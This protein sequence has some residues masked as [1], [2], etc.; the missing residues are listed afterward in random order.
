MGLNLFEKIILN[1]SDRDSIAVNDIVEVEIDG[2][3]IHDFFA[4]FCIRKFHEMGFDAVAKP[5]RVVFVYD[6]LVPASFVGD[7]DHHRAAETFVATYGITRIHRN[8]GVCHQLMHEQGYV[9]PGE[10]VVGTDSHTTT[11]GAIGAIATGIGYTEMA[12]VLGTGKLWLKVAP[13]IGIELTGMLP[14]GVFAKDVILRILGDIGSGG[15]NYR[16]LEFSGPVIDTMSIDSRLTLSNMAVE[17]GAKAG[18]ISADDRTVRYL[19]RHFDPHEINLLSSDADAVYEEV[20]SIDVSG[21]EPLV[22]CPYNVDNIQRAVACRETTI[23]QAFLGSCTNG[24]LEDIAEACRILEGRTIHPDVRFYVVPASRQVFLEAVRQGYI[25]TLVSAGAVISHPACGLC[26]GRSG[27]ILEDGERII[28]TN[29]RNFRGRMGSSKVEIYLGSP[30]TVAAS[31][32]EGRI[33]DC[34]EYL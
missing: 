11:Y 17:S 23:D 6:H 10:I 28:S 20:I 13:T 32:I 29:N 19:Q 2:M 22:A 31:A 30:A 25:K 8:D 26:A 1:H 34:R 5:E 24:R 9:L 3:M 14:K 27:G 33:A 18:L 16:V 21:M 15:A 12:A 4:P 7:Y